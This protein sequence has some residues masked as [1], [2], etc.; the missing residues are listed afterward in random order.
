[1]EVEEIKKELQEGQRSH[2]KERKKEQLEQLCTI[3]NGE[4]KL[5]S[6]PTTEEETENHQQRHHINKLQEEIESTY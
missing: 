4:Q 1:M 6:A 3:R 5:N 2:L